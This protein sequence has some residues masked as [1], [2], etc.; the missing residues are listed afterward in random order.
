MRDDDLVM[1]ATA[2]MVG[3]LRGRTVGTDQFVQRESHGV[4]WT[5][6]NV[7]ITAFGGIEE[8]NL[9]GS[10]GDLRLIPDT[11][12]VIRL[13]ANDDEPGVNVML[14]DMVNLDLTAASCC[15]RDVLRRAIT[16]LKDEFGLTLHA[17]FEHEFNLLEPGG[18][19]R[20]QW[21][22][23]FSVQALRSVEPFGTRLYQ[24]MQSAG[25]EPDTWLAEFGANQFEITMNPSDAMTAADRALLLRELVRHLASKQGWQASFSPLIAPHAIGNGVHVHFS[26]LDNEGSPIL[27]DPNRPGRL[28]ALGAS[29]AGGILHHSRAVCALATPSVVS[30]LRMRPHTWSAGHAI[31][32]LQNREA[33]L[34]ICPTVGEV[35]IERQYNLEFRAADATANPWLVM[36]ALVISGLDGLR[37]GVAPPRI[38]EG[39]Y[40]AWSQD[41]SLVDESMDLP[42]SLEE[43]LTALSKDVAF[44]AALG[45]EM[46]T[47][48][49]SVKRREINT[50]YG[51]SDEEICQQ[52]VNFY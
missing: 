34:R 13:A 40:H 46:L 23:P 1:I 36:T 33:M 39:D 18:A 44:I 15:L 14:A 43:S 25:F 19:Q 30:Y 7:A 11:S 48:Y 49:L 37:S 16:T 47:T 28:S 38:V 50:L 31:I 52:Y 45:D 27:Y 29:F 51:A 35:N 3:Q 6:A 42:T 12:N 10:I 9:F 17:A 21:G 20:A 8:P 22:S 26:I 4:G 2:D 24:A 5:P 41:A 32:G